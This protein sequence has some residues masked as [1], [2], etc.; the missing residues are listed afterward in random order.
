MN[1]WE[2]A[3]KWK[4]NRNQDKFNVGKFSDG[5]WGEGVRFGWLDEWLTGMANGKL[6]DNRTKEGKAIFSEF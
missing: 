3:L 2:C 6:G 4:R 5:F 1:K